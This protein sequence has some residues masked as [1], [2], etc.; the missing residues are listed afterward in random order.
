MKR[1]GTPITIATWLLLAGSGWSANLLSNG[2]FE[3]ALTVRWTNGIHWDPGY[4]ELT[5]GLPGWTIETNHAV[6]IHTNWGPGLWYA[7]EQHA[8]YTLLA[9]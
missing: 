7:S 5:N 9:R 2:D 4:T 6:S 1:Y 3:S 8:A